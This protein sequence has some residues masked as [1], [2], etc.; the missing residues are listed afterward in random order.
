MALVTHRDFNCPSRALA[1]LPT[2]LTTHA[3]SEAGD[4]FD[5]RGAVH[6]GTAKEAEHYRHG[7]IFR[8][9]RRDLA[10]PQRDNG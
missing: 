4:V 8:S 6:I 9:A 1:T 5:V 7:R 2:E 10:R 3:E